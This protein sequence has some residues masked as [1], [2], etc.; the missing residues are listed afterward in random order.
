MSHIHGRRLFIYVLSYFGFVCCEFTKQ[1]PMSPFRLSQRTSDRYI[2]HFHTEK[3]SLKPPCSSWHPPPKDTLTL[4]VTPP[5]LS[6]SSSSDSQP[7]AAVMQVG[8]AETT[9]SRSQQLCV[10]L[11]RAFPNYLPEERRCCQTE[12]EEGARERD[13]RQ[14]GREERWNVDD[15]GKRKLHENKEAEGKSGRDRGKGLAWYLFGLSLSPWLCRQNAIIII[16]TGFYNKFNKLL[17]VSSWSFPVYKLS[18]PCVSGTSAKT[19][20]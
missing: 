9:G 16:I 5:V 15:S 10:H 8:R 20:P 6:S 3:F 19:P 12:T 1:E 17:L 13:R 7:F 4:S 11:C 2:N 14:R 18:S